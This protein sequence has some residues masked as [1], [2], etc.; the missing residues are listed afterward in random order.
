MESIPFIHSNQAFT[1]V[2]DDDLAFAEVRAILD[3]LL[4]HDAFSVD[5]QETQPRYVISVDKESF[6]VWV[7]ETDVI[8][9]RL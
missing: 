8:I 4:D 1:I 3:H 9:K 5:I 6:N 2:Y 7:Y